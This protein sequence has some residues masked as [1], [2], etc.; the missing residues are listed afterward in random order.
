MIIQHSWLESPQLVVDPDVGD[1]EREQ[2]LAVYL[3]KNPH[4]TKKYPWDV[5]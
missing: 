5:M 2:R 3:A 4:K 1:A